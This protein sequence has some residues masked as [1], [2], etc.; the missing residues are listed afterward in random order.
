MSPAV[1]VCRVCWE[2]DPGQSVDQPSDETTAL[3]LELKMSLWVDNQGAG[4][5]G[6][7]R[8]GICY[9]ISLENIGL[10][11]FTIL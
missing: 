9:V 11:G 3:I 2:Q 10:V 8:K 5:V 6:G 1:A 7:I 4:T